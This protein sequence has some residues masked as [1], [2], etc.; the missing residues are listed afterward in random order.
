MVM[1]HNLLSS[2]LR[3]N[4]VKDKECVKFILK[5]DGMRLY[6]I[7]E[8]MEVGFCQKLEYMN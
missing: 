8:Y 3:I 7:A 4:L 6:T 1:V 2:S 5:D